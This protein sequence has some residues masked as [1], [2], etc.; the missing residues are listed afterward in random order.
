MIHT[1]TIV[2][3]III[4][5]LISANTVSYG[6][7]KGYDSIPEIAYSI[8]FDSLPPI[9]KVNRLIKLCSKNTAEFA[10]K[11]RSRNEALGV[12]NIVE[13]PIPSDKLAATI[14]QTNK[15]QIFKSSCRFYSSDL[16]VSSR[17]SFLQNSEGKIGF[18][19][20]YEV[21]GKFCTGFAYDMQTEWV[22]SNDWLLERGCTLP[23]VK[24][25]KGIDGYINHIH[26]FTLIAPLGND[27]ALRISGSW[28]DIGGKLPIIGEIHAT[29][30][31][32]ME[33]IKKS[34]KDIRDYFKIQNEDFVSQ[35]FYDKI[36]N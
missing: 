26:S 6:A 33:V 20:H 28:D 7:E 32:I 16:P 35:P 19:G 30:Q 3:A 11:L 23:G 17:D 31:D 1:C 22:K 8:M 21:V 10:C 2:T 15:E 13:F 9:P 4:F 18:V 14:T 24:R 12:L 34:D 29:Y 27:R 36:C 5:F 25:T